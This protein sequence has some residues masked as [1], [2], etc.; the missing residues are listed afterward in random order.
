L[1]QKQ[2]GQADDRAVIAKVI[3]APED[4]VQAVAEAWD[5]HRPRAAG[6]PWRPPAWARAA[7][8]GTVAVGNAVSRRAFLATKPPITSSRAAGP[9]W[10]RCHRGAPMVRPGPHRGG[11]DCKPARAR[12]VVARAVSV[13]AAPPARSPP[14]SAP[15]H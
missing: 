10:S 14:P 6:T 15:G 4:D 11:A 9:Q 2:V 3:S 7:A 8:H 1:T 5:Q 13:G 12:P